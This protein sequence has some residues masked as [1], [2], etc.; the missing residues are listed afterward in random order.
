MPEKV[1]MGSD[2]GH[3]SVSHILG[4]EPWCQLA[5][6]EVAEKEIILSQGWVGDPEA[7]LYQN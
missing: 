7:S 4:K 3:S 5:K 1:G 6:Q 2:R